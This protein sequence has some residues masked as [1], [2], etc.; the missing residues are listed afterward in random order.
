[1][2]NFYT[3][4]IFQNLELLSLKKH[5]ALILCMFCSTYL[6]EQMFER[7]WMD[8]EGNSIWNPCFRGIKAIL[9][10]IMMKPKTTPTKQILKK[11]FITY[12][13][14]QKTLGG[15]TV[16]LRERRIWIQ[17]PVGTS[18]RTN[19]RVHGKGEGSERQPGEV[20]ARAVWRG[21]PTGGLWRGLG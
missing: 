21:Q 10:Q 15:Q 19:G 11:I 4:Y 8:L 17:S 18:Q 5:A 14:N 13:T 20:A 3:Q 9:W 16:D 12:R 2:A 7:R 6:W 1:M